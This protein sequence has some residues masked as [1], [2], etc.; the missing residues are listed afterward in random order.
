MTDN[1]IKLNKDNIL[2][3][4][5]ETNE[6]EKTGEVLEFQL[7]DIELPLRYQ[8]LVEL[9]KKNREQL[10]NK[11]NIIEK[12]QDVKGKKLWSKNEEDELKA[13]MEFFEKQTEVYNMF[14]GEKGVEKLLNGRK[15]SWTTL[16]E[17]NEIIEKQILPYLK[18]SA[19]NITEQIKRKYNVDDVLKKDEEKIEVIE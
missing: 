19:E 7:D 17:I 2:R 4:S 15:F 18:K 12:R 9:D 11:I 3:L 1:I 8:E 5:I 10:R 16:N 6:G 14:L 13:V